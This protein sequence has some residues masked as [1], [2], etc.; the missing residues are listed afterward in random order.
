MP[1]KTFSDT[2]LA[3]WS[4]ILG[5]KGFISSNRA[6]SFVSILAEELGLHPVMVR[7][8]DVFGLF[9]HKMYLSAQINKKPD[10]W[11]QVYFTPQDC[12]AVTGSRA[13]NW[14]Q[15]SSKLLGYG[16]K[17][18]VHAPYMRPPPDVLPVLED[19]KQV[20]A[21]RK[22]IRFL[23][24]DVVIFYLATQKRTWK[25][26]HP[27]LRTKR[28]ISK[29]DVATLDFTP[30]ME[31]PI[32]G[33]DDLW[34]NDEDEID[35]DGVE[36]IP[37]PA[38]ITRVPKAGHRLTAYKPVSFDPTKQPLVESPV[39]IPADLS[40]MNDD[41][42]DSTIAA[43][44]TLLE[45]QQIRRAKA[46]FHTEAEAGILVNGDVWPDRGEWATLEMEFP[47]G[48]VVTYYH[49][50]L[51]EKTVERAAAQGEAHGVE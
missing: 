25:Y 11:C 39:S 5:N 9:D 10:G 44:Q 33:I 14:T 36:G 8:G 35:L 16:R 20:G 12:Q 24:L 34:G 51:M 23:T 31:E 38:P 41:E 40:E 2:A 4:Q 27:V 29:L 13:H 26:E 46:K 22:T 15:W 3:I 7:Y 32:E 18:H 47:N 37:D 48:N 17:T 45:E 43:L 21:V 1:K 42:L 30:E 28:R 6:E 50:N 49:Q 19:R